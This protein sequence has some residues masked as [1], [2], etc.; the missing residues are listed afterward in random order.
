MLPV[1][2]LY[3][4]SRICNS[5]SRVPCIGTLWPVPGIYRI[6]LCLSVSG[7]LYFMAFSGIGSEVPTANRVLAIGQREFTCKGHA[8]V[9]G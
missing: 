1:Y 9:I 7:E 6:A 3:T 2:A 5:S 4:S 8:P